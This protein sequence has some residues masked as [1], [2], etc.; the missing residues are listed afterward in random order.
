MKIIQTVAEMRTAR[1]G[2]ADLGLVP[3]MGYLHAGHLSLVAR[4]KAE[5]AAVAV[6]I[7]VNPTQFA[8]SEDLDRYPRDLPRD[9]G[10]LEAAG[11]DFVFTPEA[12]EIYPP[13]FDTRIEIGGVTEVLEGAARPGH[14]AGVATV[15]AKLFNIVQ[16]TRAYFGQKDA[17][18]SIVIRKL[19]RDLDMPVEVIVAPTVR[20][21]DGVALSSRN[22]YLGPAERAAA[23][24]I[25]RALNA[26][27]A[28]FDAGERN[29]D[30]LRQAMRQTIE[31]EPLMRV[32][33]VSITDPV[34]LRE[35][36]AVEQQALASMAARLGG[37]RLIDNLVLGA[38]TPK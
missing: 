26:A 15:V 8:P 36:A 37:T 25:F 13:G 31:A 22:S 30:V 2:V 7:F 16:P 19:V 20:E 23:P 6:S 21:T 9:L 32:D 11:V 34:T 18:Q 27:R 3:T 1:A 4:A 29:A 14:F 12:A 35:L 28:L 38:P 33:Y 17:Q 24:V 10:L 5:G